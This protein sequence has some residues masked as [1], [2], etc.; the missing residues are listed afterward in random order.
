MMP[1]HGHKTLSV[2]EIGRCG[3]GAGSSGV[4]F[5]P[6]GPPE[7]PGLAGSVGIGAAAAGLSSPTDGDG[8]FRP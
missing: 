6:T 2:A 5:R 8:L 7:D 4:L 1:P 3:A